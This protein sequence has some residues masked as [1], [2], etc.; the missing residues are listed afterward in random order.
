MGTGRPG[1]SLMEPG[2]LFPSTRLSPISLWLRASLPAS[3]PVLYCE[4]VETSGPDVGNLEARG[5]G[6]C[7]DLGLPAQCLPGRWSRGSAAPTWHLL[8]AG[9]RRNPSLLLLHLSSLTE[10]LIDFN[11]KRLSIRSW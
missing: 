7:R 1:S 6:T 2:V 5:E 8:F 4:I 3:P 11:K 10:Q 9:R